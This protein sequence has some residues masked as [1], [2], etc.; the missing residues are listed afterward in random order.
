M[1]GF[2]AV[3]MPPFQVADEFPHTARA[4]QVSRGTLVSPRY[5]GDISGALYAFGEIYQGMHFHDDLKH[6]R[7]A[8]RSAA[9]L[10]WS[11]PDR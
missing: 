10:N 3:A 11:V 7:A 5:G 8:A 4:E 2:L 9:A 6:T 1:M